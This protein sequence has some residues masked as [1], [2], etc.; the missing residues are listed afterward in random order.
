MLGYVITGA[1]IFAFLEGFQDDL[2]VETR[3]VLNEKK[4]NFLFMHS[5]ITGMYCM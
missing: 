1:I 5:C 4:M 2:N 3:V